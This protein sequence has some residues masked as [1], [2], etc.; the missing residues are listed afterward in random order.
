MAQTEM[1]TVLDSV[2]SLGEEINKLRL[3]MSNGEDRSYQE[4]YNAI[5]T[6]RNEI[7]ARVDTLEEKTFCSIKNLELECRERKEVITRARQYLNQEKMSHDVWWES[8]LGRFIGMLFGAT[9]LAMISTYLR[10]MW[11]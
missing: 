8:K 7:I 2:H 4:I 5:Y 10:K 11:E 3:E 1:R 6:M 9:L